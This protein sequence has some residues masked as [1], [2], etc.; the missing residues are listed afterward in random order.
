[1]NRHFAAVVVFAAAASPAWA[2]T[3]TVTLSVPGMDCA[4]CPITIKKALDKVPGVSKVE[5][6][7]ER[8]QAV[9]TFDDSKA[10]VASLTK[11]TADAGFP[12]TAR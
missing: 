11:A 8:K 12:S 4:A 9:V 1:M 2:E 3:K 5:A 7:F 10:D 6:S